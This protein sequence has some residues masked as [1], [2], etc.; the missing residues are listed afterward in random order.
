MSGT[1]SEAS[2]N[3]GESGDRSRERPSFE[4]QPVFKG[5]FEEDEDE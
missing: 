1:A 2:E 5:D 3:D 4:G